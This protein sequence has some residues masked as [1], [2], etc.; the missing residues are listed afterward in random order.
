MLRGLVVASLASLAVPSRSV[1]SAALYGRRAAVLGGGL[2]A[3]YAG[4]VSARTPGSTDV[5]EAVEQIRD[6]SDALRG[7]AKEWA[8]YAC[9]DGEGRACNIDAAR[10]IL[11]GVAPQR[12]DAAIEVAKSTPLYRIDGAF[13]AVRTY[14]LNA[15]DGSW[16]SALDV[17]AFVETAEDIVMASRALID[18]SAVWP[19]FL[20]LGESLTVT[21][22]CGEAKRVLLTRLA[23]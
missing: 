23:W 21:A 6:G 7:L 5:T 12:G 15:G 22:L 11:G 18:V 3:T 17:E 9:I 2:C 4:R 10:K 19:F 14:A 20:H 13:A 8:T 16:G 1:G